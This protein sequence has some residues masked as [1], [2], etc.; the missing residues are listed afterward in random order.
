[1]TKTTSLRTA[2]VLVLVA[3]AGCKGLSTLGTQPIPDTPDGTV[4]VVASRLAAN[5]PQVLWEALP[6]TYQQDVTSVIHEFAARMDPDLFSRSMDLARKSVTTLRDKKDIIL[7]TPPFQRQDIDA[8][9]LK[10]GWDIVLSALSSLLDSEIGNLESLKTI[11]PGAFFKG[12]IRE[13]MEDLAKQ[14]SAIEDDPYTTHFAQPLKSIEVEVVDND[15]ERAT[16]RITAAD[17]PP[18]TI[19][20]SRVEG[21][22][23]PTTLVER[24]PSSIA[25][26]RSQLAELTP[27]RLAQVKMQ[28]MMAFSMANAVI[29]QVAAAQTEAD[30]EAIM[31]GIFGQSMAPPHEPPPATMTR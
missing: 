22:W 3:L 4:K 21:R 10:Q 29:D 5:D 31:K 23:L 30:L 8:K 12:S 13:I 28:A 1:M 27:E 20:L 9:E 7:E 14:S 26:A 6:P 18:D 25:H 19:T 17:H 11:D 16:L 15:G 24:W 2:V